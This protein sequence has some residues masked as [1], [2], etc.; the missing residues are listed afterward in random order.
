MAIEEKR[1]FMD[2]IRNDKYLRFIDYVFRRTLE[3]KLQAV[4]SD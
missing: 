3:A 1:E 2:K 4:R